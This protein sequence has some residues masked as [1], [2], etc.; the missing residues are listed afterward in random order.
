MS[1][2]F[3]WHD[4][5]KTP[6]LTCPRCGWQGTFNEGAVEEHD[7]LMDSSCPKCWKIVAIVMYPTIAESKANWDKLSDIEKQWVDT[8]DAAKQSFEATKLK[9]V[10]QLPDLEGDDIRLSWDFETDDQGEG[11]T[12]IRRRD[13]A[14]PNPVIWRETAVFEGYERFER[15]ATILKDK[16]GSRLKELVPTSRSELYLYGDSLTA[17]DK[18]ARM[19]EKLGL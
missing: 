16:Y 6:I 1:A 17:D 7:Q 14:G 13:D 19:R 9:G 10:D 18:V 8:L 5:W 2:H 3:A 11:F 4:D 15:V 12:V